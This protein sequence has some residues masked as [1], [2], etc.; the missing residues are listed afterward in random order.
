MA[1]AMQPISVTSATFTLTDAHAGTMIVLNRA[2]GVTMTLPAPSAGLEF[3]FVVGTAPTTAYT[4]ASASSANIIVLGVNELE[5]DTADD[6][7][8]SAV[9]DLVS[10]VANVAVVGDFIKLTSDGTKW[11]GHGQTNADG[12]ITIGS[13]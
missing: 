3:Y 13:T 5:V 12:G 2:G 6:G 11:Y 4:I 10:F 8:Y 1:Y 9:G 7:P